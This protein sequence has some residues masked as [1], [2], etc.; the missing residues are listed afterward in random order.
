MN[1]RLAE[2]ASIWKANQWLYGVGG[3][4][5]GLAIG[6]LIGATMN[7]GQGISQFAGGFWAEALGIGITVF[8]IDQ[9]YRR[10]EEQCSIRERNERL[11]RQ[12][13]STVNDVARDAVHEANKV[14]LLIGDKGLLQG[15]NLWNAD[16]Q[17]AVL[18]G[19]NFHEV[20]LRESNLENAYLQWADLSFADLTNAN[21]KKS[22]LLGANLQNSELINADLSGADLTDANL[23][24]AITKS[25][26]TMSE[27][28]ERVIYE[29]E[30]DVTTILP[31]GS[32]WT[33]KTEITMFTDPTHRNFW[34]RAWLQDTENP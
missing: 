11:I 31:D 2:I 18:Q 34:S 3:L 7:F 27:S 23:V 6:F 19:V 28:G 20:N 29:T 9:F 25:D 32:N 17:K 15:K 21:M 22:L 16:L 1:A 13:G 30:F 26:P 14:D 5:T 4:F 33:Q 12:I 24:N 10:R 8:I